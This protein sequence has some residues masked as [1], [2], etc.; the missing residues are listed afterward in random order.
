MM[1]R[2]IEVVRNYFW[3]KNMEGK[4]F[5]DQDL[6]TCILTVLKFVGLI[7]WKKLEKP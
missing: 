3:G 2:E 1:I 4:C 7:Y 5:D 6:V